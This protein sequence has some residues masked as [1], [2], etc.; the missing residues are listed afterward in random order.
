[1]TNS[2]Q[3]P[4]SPGS[5]Q[6]SSVGRRTKLTIPELVN[7][8]QAAVGEYGD[9]TKSN[10]EGRLLGTLWANLDAVLDIHPNRFSRVKAKQLSRMVAAHPE[11]SVEV[12]QGGTF[13]DFGC[14]GLNPFSGMLVML[15]AG[16]ARCIGIDLDQ[17]NETLALR[18]AAKTA[19]ELIAEPLLYLEPYPVTGEQVRKNLDGL[20]ICGLVRGKVDALKG[21]P[22]EYRNTSAD[23]TGVESASVGCTTSNSFLEHVPDPDA[24]IEEIARISKPG[25]IGVHAIDGVDHRS[26]PSRTIGP[27]DFLTVD[28]KEPIVFGCNRVRPLD[29]IERFERHGFEVLKCLVTREEPVSERV[30]SKM[31]EP[32]RSMSLETLAALGV[33]LS[34][35][36]RDA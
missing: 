15:A 4:F 2:K 29:F 13:V 6:S 14:G 20:D 7:E 8:L 24:V 1:M 34:I 32:Y 3:S 11:M 19:M 28:S 25:A 36:K 35:R 21:F 5:V 22:L 18:A 23:A 27:L 16:A 30:R 17:L 12:L 9:L 26:Y 10:Y 33:R 31:V